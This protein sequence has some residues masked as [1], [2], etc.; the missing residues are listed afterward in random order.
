MGG[1]VETSSRLY[2]FSFRL[3]RREDRPGFAR[4]GSFFDLSIRCVGANYYRPSFATV[5]SIRAK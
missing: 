3:V 2:A 1:R 5:C 4:A